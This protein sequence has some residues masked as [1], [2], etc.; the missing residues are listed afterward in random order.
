MSDYEDESIY[1]YQPFSKQ[2]YDSPDNDYS[3]NGYGGV[4]SKGSPKPRSSSGMNEGE[5]RAK[6]MELAR[7]EAELEQRELDVANREDDV[8]IEG[9][10]NSSKKNWPRCYP[11]VDHT[12]KDIPTTA[13]KVMAWIGYIMWYLFS[14]TLFLNVVGSIITLI[15]ASTTAKFDFSNLRFVI[16]ALVIFFVGVPGHFALSYW[17]LYKAMRFGGVPR[18]CIFFI[19]YAIP[20]VFCLFAIGGWYE[21]GVGGLYAV[22]NYWPTTAGSPDNPFY[23]AF[24]PNLVL[25]ILW[26]VLGFCFL[27]IYIVSI[28][29]FRKQKHTFRD[30]RQYAQDSTRD[31]VS[32][33]TTRLGQAAVRS[34]VSGSQ[35]NTEE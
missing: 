8:Q 10:L 35:Q 18:F 13:G 7:R 30:V 21:Y 25:T 20:I 26:I 2:G 15:A 16:F 29:L 4:G 32:A 23:T 28:I 12:Y 14:V 1:D 17:P 34:A 19:G 3:T 11:L 24:V 27:V 22:V 33:V 9:G 6:A 5:L 31:A